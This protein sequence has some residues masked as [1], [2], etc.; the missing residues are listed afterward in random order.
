MCA[1]TQSPRRRGLKM[2]QLFGGVPACA[3]YPG[4][5]S[6]IRRNLRTYPGSPGRKPRH[7]RWP[8]LAV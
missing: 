5:G 6:A 1:W 8:L 3:E 4:T 2:P 7:D